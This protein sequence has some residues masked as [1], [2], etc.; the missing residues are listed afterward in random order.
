MQIEEFAMLKDYKRNKDLERK[1]QQIGRESHMDFQVTENTCEK[2]PDTE[3]YRYTGEKTERVRRHAET[4]QYAIR[5]YYT[6]DGN[7]VGF[8]AMFGRMLAVNC[9]NPVKFEHIKKNNTG[10]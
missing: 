8:Q 4:L 7:I 1:L 10:R 9:S 3:K 6:A 5:V 2:F